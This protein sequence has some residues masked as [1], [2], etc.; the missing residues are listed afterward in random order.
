[1]TFKRYRM[2]AAT[3]L[4]LIISLP[5]YAI[6]LDDAKARGLVGERSTGYLGIVAPTAGADVKQ[7]VQQINA[8]RRALYQ[9]KA[10]KAG[11]A[12]DV[13]E[14]RTGQRLQQMTPSGQYIQDANGR[15]VRK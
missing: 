2:L 12:L 8:K 9:K 13:M 14:L 1:M 5:A 7:L 4:A 6:S 3:L 10:G 11:V 15:W